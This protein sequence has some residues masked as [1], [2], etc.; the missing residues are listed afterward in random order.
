MGYDLLITSVA[1]QR[2]V[3]QSVFNVVGIRDGLVKPLQCLENPLVVWWWWWR[4][5]WWRGNV[6]FRDPVDIEPFGLT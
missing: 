5:R 4:W 2:A 1:E 3:G 6:G